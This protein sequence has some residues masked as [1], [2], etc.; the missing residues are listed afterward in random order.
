MVMDTS[1]KH[2]GE[3]NEQANVGMQRSDALRALLQLCVRAVLAPVY[4][5]I[6]VLWS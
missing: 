2:M 4:F 1:H 5:V 3:Q 6:A